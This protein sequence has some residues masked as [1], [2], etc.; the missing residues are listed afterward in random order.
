[1]LNII[2]LPKIKV[3]FSIHF[4]LKSTLSLHQF[5]VMQDKIHMVYYIIIPHFISFFIYF[6][7]I[8]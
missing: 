7:K 3:S 2:E 5:N 4:L 6:K 1:M 8:L